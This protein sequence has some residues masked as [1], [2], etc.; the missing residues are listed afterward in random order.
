[1]FSYETLCEVFIRDFMRGF[2]TRLYGRFSY[3]TLWEIFIRDFIGGFH[4]R[5][6]RRFSN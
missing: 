6:Y 3:E 2:H 1:M 5:V 4:T